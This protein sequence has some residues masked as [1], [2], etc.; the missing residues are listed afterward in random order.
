MIRYD[1]RCDQ[2]HQFD[3]WYADSA[4]FDKLA[5]ADLVA[6]PHCGSV[7]IRKAIMAPNVS[8]RTRSREDAARP[9][10]S[11]AAIADTAGV[12]TSGSPSSTASAAP[13]SRVAPAADTTAADRAEKLLTI[14][15][16]IRRVVEQNAENVGDQFAQEARKIHYG[17]TEERA[18]YG[19]A[20]PDDAVEMIEEGIV[21]HPLP[22]LPEDKN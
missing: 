16:D 7:A 17:E 5:A 10:P 2:D 9:N 4:A 1:L 19:Q 13:T 15:R 20:T 14:M 3:G 6:C 21:V 8:L 18:I 11:Q 22:N 12:P